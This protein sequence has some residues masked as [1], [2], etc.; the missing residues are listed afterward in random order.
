MLGLCCRAAPSLRTAVSSTRAPMNRVSQFMPQT[1]ST[2]S[3]LLS[4]R[5]FSSALVSTPTRLQPSQTLASRLPLTTTSTPASLSVTSFILQQP[6]QSRSFSATAAL[7]VKRTTFRPSRRVQKRRHGFLSRN[8]AIK[9]R[10]TL[11]R[12]RMKGRKAMSW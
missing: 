6:Q 5:S 7:G 8:R 11:I 3:A 4:S 12:R 1:T 2:P 10:Q 9:G